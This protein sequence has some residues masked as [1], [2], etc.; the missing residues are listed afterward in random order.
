MRTLGRRAIMVAG[1]LSWS[2]HSFAQAG[3]SGAPPRVQGETFALARYSTGGAASFYVAARVGGATVL[4]GLTG[5]TQRGAPTSIA[6]L[7]T[8]FR[9][10]TGVSGSVFAAAART[11][12]DV[13]ARLYV[14]PNAKVGRVVISAIGVVSQS[15]SHH[16]RQLSINPLM[17][18]YRVSRWLQLGGSAAAERI[19]Q[20][21]SRVAVG[22]AAHAGIMRMRLSVEA[23]DA[24]NAARREV[25]ISIVAR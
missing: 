25:R 2:S 16:G 23:Y 15:T 18:G 20:R 1:I 22:P 8:R 19:G 21:S 7:G 24:G 4:A 13:Q 3:A 11:P 9:F 17:A 14:L 12:T 6:G 10:A 5:N